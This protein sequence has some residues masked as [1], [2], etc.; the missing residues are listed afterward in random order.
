M[1]G[2][3]Y[4]VTLAKLV[5]LSGH[6]CPLLYNWDAVCITSSQVTVR[7]KWDAHTHGFWSV[8]SLCWLSSS[9]FY[10]VVIFLFPS[11]LLLLLL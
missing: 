5:S 2:Q 11:C 1:E 9:L 10:A 3:I 8:L 4:S 6:Q 7:I